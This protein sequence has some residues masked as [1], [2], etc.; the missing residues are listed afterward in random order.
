MMDGLEEELRGEPSRA[1]AEHLG[2][3]SDGA[4]TYGD[5]ARAESL[6]AEGVRVCDVLGIPLPATLLNARGELR[7]MSGDVEGERDIREAVEHLLDSGQPGIATDSLW[8]LGACLRLWIGIA[9]GPIADEAIQLCRDRGVGGVDGL[10]ILRLLSS[11]EEGRWD[12]VSRAEGLAERVRATGDLEDESIAC[13]L[14]GS[15]EMERKGRLEADR[16]LDLS[17]T[18]SPASWITSFGASLLTRCLEPQVRRVGVGL[19]EAMAKIERSATWRLS[20]EEVTSAIAAGRSSLP[21]DSR[22]LSLNGSTD[23]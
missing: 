4:F 9:A 21:A 1:R 7:I 8:N 22:P 19:L 6:C 16:L 5:Q 20:Y 12:E 10:L 11:F 2:A 15:V 13:I 23:S 3:M 18:W 17:E 14:L